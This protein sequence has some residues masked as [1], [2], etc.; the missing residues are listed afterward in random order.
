MATIKLQPSGAVVIKDGKVACAC[1]GCWIPELYNSGI[2]S[3]SLDY[4]GGGF[5]TGDGVCEPSSGCP[6]N[7]Y[8]TQVRNSTGANKIYILDTYRD[9]PP[10]QPPFEAFISG[11]NFGFDFYVFG[12]PCDCVTEFAIFKVYFY[13]FVICRADGNWTLSVGYESPEISSI[14]GSVYFKSFTNPPKNGEVID[15]KFSLSW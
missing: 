6:D 12:P 3:I 1:C 10:N 8:A 14:F 9:T 13:A 2:S 5:P 7:G 15:G 11:L 4:F